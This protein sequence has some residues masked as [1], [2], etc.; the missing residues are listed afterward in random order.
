MDMLNIGPI[1]DVLEGQKKECLYF[2]CYGAHS[3]SLVPGPFPL[4]NNVFLVNV[5]NSFFFPEAELEKSVFTTYPL[6]WSLKPKI[7]QTPLDFWNMFQC[8]KKDYI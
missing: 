4:R 2:L 1:T 5:K 7:G 8:S 6:G 3:L